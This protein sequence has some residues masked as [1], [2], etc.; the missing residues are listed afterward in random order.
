MPVAPALSVYHPVAIHLN[1]GH[2]HP[3]VTR[4]SAGVLWPVDRLILASDMTTAPPDASLVSSSVRTAL[5][6]PHWRRAMEEEYAALLAN[7]T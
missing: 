4:R 7:H 5:A 2:V 1:L 6:N 3:M